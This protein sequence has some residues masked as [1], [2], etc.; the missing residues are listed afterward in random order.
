[1][2]MNPFVDCVATGAV[3]VVFVVG[4][5]VGA[6]DDGA[7]VEGLGSG[8]EAATAGAG[9]TTGAGVGT[10]GT[11]AG[12][13]ARAGLGAGGVM[14]GVGSSEIGGSGVT[15][16]PG[17]FTTGASSSPLLAWADPEPTSATISTSVPNRLMGVSSARTVERTEF[18]VFSLELRDLPR[19]RAAL[20]SQRLKR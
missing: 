7:V 19:P 20:L 8:A 17:P 16:G 1:M 11:G 12:A 5:V 18:Q 10:T 2:V 9:A 3:P 15:V 4:A 6:G 13:G 14:V